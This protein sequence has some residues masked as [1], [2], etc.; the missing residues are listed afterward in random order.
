MH[1]IR[2]SAKQVNIKISKCWR[3]FVG[4]REKISNVVPIP[5][6]VH[7]QERVHPH[8]NEAEFHRG[9]NY[10]NSER[11]RALTSRNRV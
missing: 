9:H 2:V 1:G 10:D 7:L 4:K 11:G 6:P 8:C 3:G 5:P